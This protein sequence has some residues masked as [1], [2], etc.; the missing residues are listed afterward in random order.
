MW[1]QS[2]TRAAV[3]RW[4]VEASTLLAMSAAISEA[5]VGREVGE[6]ILGVEDRL[7]HQDLVMEE[8]LR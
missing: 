6:R 4:E 1:Q 5:G 2:L 8:E 7:V 3:P